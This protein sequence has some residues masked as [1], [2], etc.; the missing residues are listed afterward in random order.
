MDFFSWLSL[1]VFI[2]AV[3]AA[4]LIRK[5]KEYKYDLI[6]IAGVILNV[7]FGVMVYPPICALALQIAGTGV[8]LGELMPA[9]CV[10]GIG[11]SVILRRKERP[12]LSFLVQFAGVLCFGFV[13]LQAGGAMPV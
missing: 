11:A 7:V 1:A 8:V 10:A 2:I 12:W 9:V 5:R 3:L 13:W 6:D 4:L